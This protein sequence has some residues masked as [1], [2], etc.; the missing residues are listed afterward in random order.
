MAHTKLLALADDVV[1]PGPLFSEQ[2][3]IY[4]TNVVLA[5]YIFSCTQNLPQSSREMLIHC[6]FCVVSELTDLNLA[7][8]IYKAIDNSIK[9][10]S[11]SQHVMN[12]ERVH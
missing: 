3:E 8:V 7:T 1:Y 10:L 6:K 2:E 4:A 12:Y 11:Q 5:A 9:L